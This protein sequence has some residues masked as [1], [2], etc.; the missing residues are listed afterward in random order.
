V[1]NMDP[2]MHDI[3]AYEMSHL[4]P[5]V[6]FNVLLPI[7]E[8]YPPQAG[9]N[10]RFSR[11]YEGESITQ[12]G[13]MTKNRRVFVMQCGFHAYY[14]KLGIGGGSSVLWRRR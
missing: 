9:L 10:P 4:G 13:H 2:A 7:S 6:L 8:R 1:V 12:P 3:Q 14:G 5:G 11:Y